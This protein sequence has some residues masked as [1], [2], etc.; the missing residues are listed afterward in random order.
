MP[1]VSGPTRRNHDQGA[2]DKDSRD[3]DSDDM[4]SHHVD[5]YARTYE[6]LPKPPHELD[7]VPN[8][9]Q[10]FSGHS[11]ST[12][13]D[14]ARDDR[15]GQL[16]NLAS[17]KQRQHGTHYSDF[18]AS[19]DRFRLKLA[20]NSVEAVQKE[21]DEN[22]DSV[23]KEDFLW[24]QE[25]QLH[26]YTTEEIAALLITEKHDSPWIYF[27]SRQ[28]PIETII[29][30]HHV[31][32][33]VHQEGQ[34]VDAIL[35]TAIGGLKEEHRPSLESCNENLSF[36]QEL[37]GIAG[38]VPKTRDL[39]KWIGSVTFVEDQD[40]LTAAVTY[41]CNVSSKSETEPSES[42][43]L[44][45]HH[46][47]R[48]KRDIEQS[49]KILQGLE[50]LCSAIALAQR[51]GMCCDSFTILKIHSTPHFQAVMEL[52]RV[53]V[54]TV[55]ILKSRFASFLDDL[56]FSG[57]E[58]YNYLTPR[59]PDD[60]DEWFLMRYYRTSES[61]LNT[62]SLVTQ[63]LIL[64]FFSYINAHVGSLHQFFLDTPLSDVWLFGTEDP[65][66]ESP[67]ITA[68]LYRLTCLE[69]M[70]QKPVFAFREDR[71][72][73][74]N[75]LARY[76]MLASPEDLVDTWGPGQ[77]VPSDLDAHKL[78]AIIIGG[79]VIK[80]V[81][82]NSE[83]LHWSNDVEPRHEFQVAFS[84]KKKVLIAGGVVPNGACQV[85][86]SARWASFEIS[87]SNLGTA[88]DYWKFTEFQVGAV[89]TGQQFVGAQAGF[90][91]TWTWHP[92][93]SW[94]MVNLSMIAD[95]LPFNILDRPWGLQV[96]ACTGVSKRVPLR[97][98][99]ADT[100][101]AFAKGL[102][103]SPSWLILQQRGLITALMAGGE[104][105]RLWY[106]EL[107]SLPNFLD[108][109]ILTKRLIRHILLVL[110]DTGIDREG[111]IF[112]IGCPEEHGE[113]MYTYLPIP[114]EN[115][116]LWAQIL[117]DSEDC[118]TFAYM[119][120][121][122]L[123]TDEHRCQKTNPWHCPSLDT[124]VQHF[125]PANDPIIVPEQA[126]DLVTDRLYWIGMPSSGLQARVVQS[127]NSPF[128]RLH[129]SKSIVPQRTR[130]RLGTLSRLLGSKKDRL[131]E[132]QFEK[133][134]VKD[135]IILSQPT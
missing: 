58:S 108:L 113:S 88:A 52:C 55:L 24:I 79:G 127:A 107:Q 105:I 103:L 42:P 124:A 69:G 86:K 71:G 57:A 61:F 116:N 4:N 128:P 76:D 112:K 26:G 123:E 101:P 96:S 50:H 27:E 125:R 102:A 21:L 119:T 73:D 60:F 39:A 19:L 41:Q 13:K 131:R 68:S 70:I 75:R 132:K 2:H 114:C 81:A 53:Q 77:F 17:S 84:S 91:K 62:Y 92:G 89:V 54:T 14:S 18:D 90:N 1:E 33:C 78:S 29:L 51:S 97:I 30:S 59:F 93:N 87:L 130:A 20:S 64:G 100:M 122:C 3:T 36:I 63:F 104:N 135:V 46:N 106:D 109:Q 11:G 6:Q 31:P 134:F 44:L 98:L 85:N 25:L 8:W 99:L 80:P 22:F 7:V 110:R 9:M 121:I 129:I 23:A 56:R 37:C 40:G 94:K 43:L 82:E 28:Y 10:H 45:S 34:D 49:S 95:D 38:V 111:K 67:S 115:E 32:F 5:S 120:D 83:T 117:K 48:E 72:E 74:Y 12:F 133:G 16:Q 47:N 66:Y 126:W 15:Q 118:A 65:K 35:A